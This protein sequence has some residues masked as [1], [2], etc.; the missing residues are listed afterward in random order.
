MRAKLVK[1]SVAAA[2]VLATYGADAKEYDTLH[3][4]AFISG[5]AWLF[6]VFLANMKKPLPGEN[7]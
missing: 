4:I 5:T 7:E 3:I 1:L 6:L 2:I